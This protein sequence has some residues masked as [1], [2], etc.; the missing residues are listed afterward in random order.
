MELLEKDC[1]MLSGQGLTI[2]MCS[3]TMEMK[4]G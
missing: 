1:K 3:V 4:V 2:A